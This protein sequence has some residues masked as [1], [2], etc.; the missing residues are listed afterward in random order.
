MTEITAYPGDNVRVLATPVP[1]TLAGLRIIDRIAEFEAL[2][3]RKPFHRDFLASFGHNYITWPTRTECTGIT[4]HHTLSH[5]PRATAAYITKSKGYPTTQYAYWVSADDGC[6]VYQCLR[7]SV[8]CWHDHTGRLQTTISI[9][10]AGKLHKAAPSLEQMDACA[11]LCVVLM[12]RHSF[13]TDQ[14]QGHLARARLVKPEPVYTVC[15]G[16]NVS[17]WRSDFFGLLADR[18]GELLW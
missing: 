4:I 11:Q 9:G 16:W 5:S 10:M 2:A 13:G 6:P 7:D 12:K 18:V 14:V 15:P 17:G 1:E 8:A 3:N